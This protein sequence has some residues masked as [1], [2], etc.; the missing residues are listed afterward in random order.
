MMLYHRLNRYRGYEER[1]GASVPYLLLLS[2]RT[3][4]MPFVEVPWTPLPPLPKP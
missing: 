2:I 1:K 3:N 4:A